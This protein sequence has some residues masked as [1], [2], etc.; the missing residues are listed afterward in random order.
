MEQAGKTG[1]AL[2][3]AG[4][5]MAVAVFAA[6]TSIRQLLDPVG[7]IAHWSEFDRGGHFPAMETPDSLVGDLR[8]F[9]HR[10]AGR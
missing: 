3:Q 6:N 9:F 1:H 7:A 5:P 10:P 4:P 2:P 8:A